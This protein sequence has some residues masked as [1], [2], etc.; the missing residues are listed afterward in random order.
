MDVC[1]LPGNTI[2]RRS[3]HRLGSVNGEGDMVSHHEGE[4]GNKNEWIYR[5]LFL[6]QF[7]QNMNIIMLSL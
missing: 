6:I 5:I 4:P 1:V 2:T 7:R 3:R